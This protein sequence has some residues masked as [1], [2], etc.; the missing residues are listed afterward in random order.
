MAQVA[1]VAGAAVAGALANKMLSGGK[2][3][4]D[5]AV[6]PV[7]SYQNYDHEKDIKKY[8]HLAQEW[9]EVSERNTRLDGCLAIF[10]F[11]L[12][13]F[14][15]FFFFDEL[16]A[17]LLLKTF[18]CTHHSRRRRRALPVP[19]AR[20]SFPRRASSSHHRRRTC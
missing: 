15:F 11:R 20:Y 2:G 9:P 14:V 18:G 5:D 4:K 8:T 6:F 3:S 7:D 1:V 16:S 17:M 10:S 12:R 19:F 13:L